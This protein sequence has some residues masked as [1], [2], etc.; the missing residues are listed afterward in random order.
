MEQRKKNCYNSSMEAIRNKYL[1]KYFFRLAGILCIFG[2]FLLFAQSVKALDSLQIRG[3]AY[4]GQYGYIYFNCIDDVIGNRLDETEN[5]SGAGLYVDPPEDEL[6]HFYSAPCSNFTHSVYIDP[7]G[8]VSG[9]AWNANFGLI[10]FDHDG[11]DPPG[12]FGSFNS[13]CSDTCNPSTNC[14]ACYVSSDQTLYGWGRIVSTGEWIRLDSHP[15]GNT[16]QIYTNDSMPIYPGADLNLGDF[17]GT[18]ASDYGDISFNCQTENYP[19]ADTC[20]SRDY[21]VYIKNLVLGRL[22]APNWTYTN[23]CSSADALRAVLRWDR[24][25]GVQA[26]YE[27]VINDQ[28]TFSTTTSDFVCWTGKKSGSANQYI[29]Y[30]YPS[31]DCP[32]GLDYD[33]PYYWWVRGYDDE[34]E[35]TGWVKY[36]TNSISDS[37]ENRDANNETFQ[38]FLHEFPSP[39]F[40]WDP[41]EVKTSTST[42][43]TSESFAYDSLSPDTAQSCAPSLCPSYLWETSDAN[44]LISATTSNETDIIF[45]SAT[46][47]DVTLTVTDADGYYCSTS[48]TFSINYDLPLWREVK[49]Q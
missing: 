39:F 5:L 48:T 34:D 35:T 19:G 43:F 38:T 33:T 13:V 27:I 11:I 29:A 20:L 44:A 15:S 7:D 10:S 41:L 12:G 42:T 21:K 45:Y 23:A 4:W 17:A 28:P 32:S 8:A 31:S 25:S 26:A 1:N 9:E 18:A 6:F 3:K 24:L 49:P 30:G 36:D 46:N 47:T 16:S 14:I 22:S 37:D 40:S 2:F